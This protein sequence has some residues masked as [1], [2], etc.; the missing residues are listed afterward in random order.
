MI[1]NQVYHFPKYKSHDVEVTWLSVTELKN[2]LLETLTLFPEPI[3]RLKSLD[4]N[5]QSALNHV[6]T[7]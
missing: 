5:Y 3:T 7:P 4:F 1:L 6:T 2:P